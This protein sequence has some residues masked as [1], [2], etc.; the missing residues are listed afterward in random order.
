VVTSFKSA[1]R[2]LYFLLVSLLLKNKVLL[3]VARFFLMLVMVGIRLTA[4]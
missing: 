3:R 1:E 2:K 4:G